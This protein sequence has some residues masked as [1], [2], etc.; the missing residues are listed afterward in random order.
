MADPRSRR[1][2]R[3]AVRAA[4]FFLRIRAFSFRS[5][6]ILAAGL[7]LTATV[8]AFSP[9]ALA[10]EI[11]GKVINGTT[12]TPVAGITVNVVDPRHGMATEEEIQTD[13]Q[14]AYAAKDLKGEDSLYLVQVTYG[15]VNYTEIVRPEESKGHVEIR[16]YETTTDWD[17]LSVSLPHLMARRSADT[18]SIDRIFVVSNRTIP[19]KTVQGAGA[20]FRLY[21]P[22]EKLQI[23]SLFATSLG[24]PISVVPR[25][26][27]TPGIF[28]IDYPFKPGD[29]QVG[30][31][32]DVD[33]KDA[34]Y[35]YA[36]PLQYP[37]DE[38]VVIA[39]DPEMEVTSDTIDL[40]K[41]EDIRGLKAH[42]LSRLAR[43]STLALNFRGGSSSSVAPSAPAAD[44]EIITLSEPW[45]NASVILIT[46]FFLLLVLAL[47]YAAK[48][49]VEES[50]EMEYLTLR[51]GS[52]ATQIA[53]L[54][55]LF[56]TGTVSDQLY[57]AK[58][59][60]LVEA[61]SRVMYRIE[62]VQPKKSRAARQG[63]GTTH[64]R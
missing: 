12:D 41:S 59:S 34:R 26:T 44:H 30:V 28:T 15:G 47:A 54:D 10:F 52:I 29:T 3:S 5:S 61:L 49:A 57:K 55:D 9:A 25:P 36:E 27:E 11:H 37:L 16:V 60:E 39:D 46:G 35:A 56:A 19:P 6:S 23:T 7:A 45:Q 8:T 17:S 58:R 63:K 43:S 32:F 21:I 42:R 1:I 64:A 48:S 2:E 40:G 24:I 53:R 20:G 51:K 31:S 50:D 4:S 38:V 33:Y 14:G 13:S 18:L 62:S 22:E